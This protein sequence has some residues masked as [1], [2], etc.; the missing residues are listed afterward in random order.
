[1]PCETPTPFARAASSAIFR[2][3]AEYTSLMSGKRGP[4]QLLQIRRVAVA[5]VREPGTEAIVVG[6]DQRVAPHEID[7]I[8][9]DHQRALCERGVDAARGVGQNETLHAESSHHARG[10]H[11]GCEIVAFVEMHATRERGDPPA[12]H[13]ADDEP[14]GMTDNL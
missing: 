2:K 9:D 11:D 13:R 12:R 14:A 5:H 7:V 6:P 1:M 3:R 10:E 8:V 4:E